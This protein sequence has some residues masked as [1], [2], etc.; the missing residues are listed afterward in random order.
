MGDLQAFIA[1]GGHAMFIWP[2]YAAAF[3]VL[4]GLAITDVLGGDL[5]GMPGPAEDPIDQR[6]AALRAGQGSRDPV[7]P[8][9]T[10]LPLLVQVAGQVADDGKAVTAQR[11]GLAD[12]GEHEQAGRLDH[13][14][15]EHRFLFGPDLIMLSVHLH[16]HAGAPRP[17]EGEGVN[18]RAGQ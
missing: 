11:L 13:T 4:G 9:I 3:A 14:R 6:P 15:A 2:A 10:A 12:P 7:H 18:A 5:R 1:M 17:L 16:P 8:G